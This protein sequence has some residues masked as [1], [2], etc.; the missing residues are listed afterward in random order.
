MQV[1]SFAAP[2]TSLR[3][4]VDLDLPLPAVVDQLADVQTAIAVLENLES[5]LKAQLV[6]SGL[7]EICG[8]NVR[9]TVS[10]I[11]EGTTVEW[12]ALAESFKPTPEELATFS[13]KR[14]AQVRVALKGYN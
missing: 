12:K 14:E 9:A 6:A 8:S 11:A 3:Q 7:K 2:V 10:R 5:N 13:K 4:T 1:Q